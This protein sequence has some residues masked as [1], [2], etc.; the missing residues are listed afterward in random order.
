MNLGIENEKVEFKE[1][2]SQLDKGLKSLTAM[3][4]RNGSGTVFFGVDDDGNV[5]KKISIGKNTLLE[6]RNR[7]KQLIEPQI[8]LNIKEEQSDEGFTYIAVSAK[9]YDIPYS[10]DGRFFIRTAASDEAI[11]SGLL[12]KML[13]NNEVDIIRQISSKEQDL[14]FHKL[15]SHLTA[16][17]YHVKDNKQFYKSFSLLNDDGEFN[18]MSYLL[19]DKNDFSIKVAEFSGKD[20]ASISFRTEYGNQCLINSVNAVLDYFKAL[21]TSKIDLSDGVR[22]ETS[23]FD[24]EAFREAWINACLHNSWQEEL[25]PAVYLFDD[26]IEIVSYGGLTY[27]L[28]KEDFYSGVSMPVNKSLLFVFAAVGLAEQTGHGIPRI[29]DAYGREAFI[30]S[31]NMITVNIP[32]KYEP[33]FV[34]LRKEREKE[35]TIL[36]ENQKSILKYLL[37]NDGATLQEVADHVGLSLAGVKSNVSKLQNK[38]FL[39]RQGSKKNGLWKVYFKNKL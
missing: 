35:G 9:G 22:Q 11:S 24:Y 14:T 29:V 10:C 4:N 18:L 36:S 26:R 1:S 33:E 34:S 21:N 16:N 17:G 32:F 27:R 39:S 37:E 12:R 15:I 19:A 7:A 38:G 31:E 8:V 25:A 13:I 28:T 23:L 3:L 20:K 5:N 2:L 6:I 30:F